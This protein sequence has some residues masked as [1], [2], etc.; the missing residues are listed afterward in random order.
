MMYH[1][2]TLTREDLEKFKALRVI[3]RIGSGYDN[4]DIKAAGELGERGRDG[5]VG[6]TGPEVQGARAVTTRQCWPARTHHPDTAVLGSPLRAPPVLGAAFLPRSLPSSADGPPPGASCPALAIGAVQ[7]KAEAADGHPKAGLMLHDGAARCPAKSYVVWQCGCGRLGL[8]HCGTPKQKTRGCHPPSAV[9]RLP[10][11][12]SGELCGTWLRRWNLVF[13][14]P[15]GQAPSSQPP[16]GPIWPCTR[17]EEVAPACRLI[18][19]PGEV[20]APASALSICFQPRRRS[21][22]L[23]VATEKLGTTGVFRGKSSIN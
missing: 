7:R 22:P 21:E 12:G 18:T 10:C 23:F 3:V 13:L 5:L 4:V 1:T 6:R 9:L 16:S 8:P 19:G 17:V 20:M 14:V 11:P 15:A 2:I